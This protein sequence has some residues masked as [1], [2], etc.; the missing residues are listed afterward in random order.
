MRWTMDVVAVK[1]LS[2]SARS[3]SAARSRNLRDRRE[4]DDIIAEWMCIAVLVV[5]VLSCCWVELFSGKLHDLNK[6]VSLCKEG[7]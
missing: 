3:T 1:S 5:V 7:A 2:S 6:R 4:C